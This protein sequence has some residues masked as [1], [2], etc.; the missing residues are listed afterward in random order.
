MERKRYTFEV[1][2]E[3]D[4]EAD[5]DLSLEE[6]YAYADEVL[7]MVLRTGKFDVKDKRL[8]CVKAEYLTKPRRIFPDIFANL[9]GLI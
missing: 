1:P 5:A 8:D 2:I 9:R 7:T 3:F 4:F 6:L